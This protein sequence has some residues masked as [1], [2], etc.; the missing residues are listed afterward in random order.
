MSL[1]IFQQKLIGTTQQLVADNLNILNQ[2]SRGAI[3]MG[4]AQTIKD[5]VETMTI[6][7]IDGLATDR[8]V[9][10]PVGTPAVAKVITR[11]LINKINVPGKIGPVAIT[12]GM[13]DRINAAVDS[14]AGEVA[15]SAT[16]AL[17]T[18]A[19]QLGVGAA[20]AAIST[21]SAAIYTQPAYTAPVAGEKY[22]QLSDFPLAAATFGD[23][24]D[25]IAAWFMS[26]VQWAR[27]IARQA[28]PSAQQVFALGNIR[29]MQDGL[30]RAFVVSDAAASA[31]ANVNTSTTSTA[32][33]IGQDGAVIGLVTGGVQIEYTGLRM[34]ADQK[35]GGE[36]IEMWW[37][38]E[39]EH[40]V[41]LKGYS[42]KTENFPNVGT[43][44]SFALADLL[45]AKNWKKPV[46]FTD[47]A[48]LK[49]DGTPMP[50]TKTPEV[51]VKE[52]AG[53]LMMLTNTAA[54]APAA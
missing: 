18:R 33:K 1:Q 36:N 46:G 22:P 37:Q 39:F 34:A 7:L 45:E 53:V 11:L 44:Q 28:V 52:T 27:F 49:A 10:A 20:G 6:G 19:I 4:N 5:F 32:K 21:N 43:T 41:A 40:G 29:V 48:P 3:V 16:E 8:N 23:Q 47:N 24:A 25:L 17:A 15:A 26:G 14:V 38:G 30:G 9:Y 35:V 31:L 2:Q 12:T 51:N 50:A 42:F 13:M 54:N